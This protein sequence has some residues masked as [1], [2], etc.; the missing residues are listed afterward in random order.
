MSSFDLTTTAKV[1]A[2]LGITDA[3]YDDT[4][5]DIVTAVSCEIELYCNRQFEL[6]T[7]TEQILGNGESK[8]RLRNTPIE[9]ILYSAVGAQ[10]V[11]TVTY[12]GAK[13]ASIDVQAREVR[14]IEGLSQTDVAIADD[15]TLNDV[16]TAI[17]AVTG[18]TAEI[19]SAD[20]GVY[21]GR[22][23]FQR[24]YGTI[25]SGDDINLEAAL[26][27]L[28]LAEINDGLYQANRTLCGN[29]LVIYSGGYA[30]D[31]IPAGLEQLATQICADTFK[32]IQ[33]QANLKG[34]KIGDYSY[35]LNTEVKTAIEAYT[36][37]LDFYAAMVI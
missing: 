18:W 6:D 14:L 27:Q 7:Y 23:L 33:Q 36:T 31:A 9:G 1:K 11:M 8:V 32:S 20:I 4:I 5:D 30:A 22:I 28:A 26:S 12:S 21:P 25:E 17:S 35:S 16:V 10:T 34:E 24:N 15:D 19:C 13:T 29:T 2:Y 3:A 37:R